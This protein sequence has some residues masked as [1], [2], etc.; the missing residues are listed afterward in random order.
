MRSPGMP[1]AARRPPGLGARLL[2][3]QMLVLVTAVVTAGLVAAAVGPSLF[4]SHLAQLSHGDS[5]ELAAVHAEQAFRQAG[6][7]SVA[8]ALLAALV[9][10]VLV[11]TY[12]TRRITRPVSALAKAASQVA[13][14][15]YAV[16]IPA[17]QLGEEFD[18]MAAS[19]TSMAR[20]LHD[21]EKTRR[22]LLADLAHEMRTPV[23]T[24]DA[25]LEGVEDGVATMDAGTVTMLRGQTRRL[26][27]LAEDVS[28]VSRAEE[29]QLDLNRSAARPLD[30][31]SSA[32]RSATDRFCEKAVSLDTSI[33][34]DLPLIDVD[35]DRFG[36][37]LGNLLDNALRHTP[38]GGHV[39]ITGTCDGQQVTIAVADDG[40]GIPAEA[41]PHVFERFFRVDT[42]RD[43]AHGG[44]GIGLA[45]VKAIVEAH[46]GCVSAASPGGG[47]GATFTISLPALSPGRLGEAASSSP[48]RQ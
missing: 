15:H 41:L 16:T 9:S 18:S 14:G 37:V 48:R 4:H 32:V 25:Y 19:F 46:Q 20:Q 47:P 31:V 11:S 1:S 3:A 43:R 7:I 12:I 13:D 40:D 21:V 6:L 28:A 38:Q 2:G 42:A 44:S 45:I 35:P 24:L 39:S 8:V 36:Q 17:P 33:P 34:S 30:L 10:A 29:H 22:R 5:P 26:A 23:A 27:R